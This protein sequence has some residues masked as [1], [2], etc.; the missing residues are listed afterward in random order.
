MWFPFL[1]NNIYSVSCSRIHSLTIQF[2]HVCSFLHVEVFKKPLLPTDT[3]QLGIYFKASR[4]TIECICISPSNTFCFYSCYYF[5]LF[6]NFCLTLYALIQHAKY[7]WP[8]STTR[9]LPL[10][11]NYFSIFFL[12]RNTTSSQL[13]IQ[14]KNIFF[15]TILNPVKFYSHNID[16]K[17]GG[18]Q[19]QNI[20]IKFTVWPQLIKNP[21]AIQETLVPFLGREDTLEKG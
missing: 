20:D 4:S 12:I 10:L 6:K 16:I 2:H 7:F 18:Y 19:I 15:Y 1:F 3:P 5:C 17:M 11:G 9:E 8:D 21:P 14:F 13:Y